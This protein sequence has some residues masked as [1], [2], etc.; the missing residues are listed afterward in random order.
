MLLILV[1]WMQISKAVKSDAVVSASSLLAVLAAGIGIHL[2]FLAFN[3]TA[4]SVL[5]LG[6]SS[7]D[8]GES[9]VIHP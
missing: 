3:L 6:K 1:P 7:T 8:N 2:V 5:Q 4:T 9:V